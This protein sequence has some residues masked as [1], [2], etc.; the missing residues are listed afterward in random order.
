M[1]GDN[2]ETNKRK[3]WDEMMSKLFLEY[4]N[5]NFEFFR[6]VE[7]P[8]RKPIISDVMYNHYRR[9]RGE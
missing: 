2:S 8:E 6:T 7:S 4:V 5:D 1:Q 9:M 3:Y